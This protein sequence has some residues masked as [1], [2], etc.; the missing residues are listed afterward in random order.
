MISSV[1]CDVE[2]LFRKNNVSEFSDEII[3]L[4]ASESL[5]VPQDITDSTGKLYYYLKI[6]VS[7]TIFSKLVQAY[8]S[9][10]PHSCGPERAVSCHI[11]LKTNKQ[12]AY[13]R[14]AINSRL[15]IAKIVTVQ[16]I[17]IRGRQ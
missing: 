8:I 14:E 12:T 13:S 16:Q 9:L 1:Q 17:L 11:I 10:T 6:S 5:P 2:G 3:G 4:Y 7:K 15:F